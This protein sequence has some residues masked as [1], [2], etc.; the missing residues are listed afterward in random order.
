FSGDGVFTYIFQRHWKEFWR[1]GMGS[2]ILGHRGHAP[3][4]AWRFSAIPTIQYLLP[5]SSG[6]V[7]ATVAAVIPRPGRSS[8]RNCVPFVSGRGERTPQ[9]CGFTINVWQL[10]ENFSPATLVIRTGICARTLVPS[11]RCGWLIV[12]EAILVCGF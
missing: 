8:M 9:P 2:P 7:Q 4:V 12:E 5:S 1:G 11:R 10:S 3:Q 6:R